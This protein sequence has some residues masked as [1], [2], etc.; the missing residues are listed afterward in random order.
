[1]SF[2]GSSRYIFID[3]FHLLTD[4][5]IANFIGTLANRLPENAHLIVAS[6]DRFLMQFQADILGKTIRRPMIRETTGLGAAY[7]AG[8][9][10]GVW[11]DKDSIRKMWSCDVTF[12]PQMNSGERD[13]LCAGWHKAVGRSLGWASRTEEPCR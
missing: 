6:R 5:R 1:M 11:K 8:L 3:D 10:V 12:E 4:G 13:R 7:L 2:A 9:A